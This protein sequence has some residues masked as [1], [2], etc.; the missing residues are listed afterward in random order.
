LWKRFNFCRCWQKT[1]RLKKNSREKRT[2][3]IHCDS[4]IK[5]QIK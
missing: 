3:K 4:Y 2:V 1:M 5:A